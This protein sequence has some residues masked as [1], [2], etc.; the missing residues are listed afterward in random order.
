MNVQNSWQKSPV[1]EIIL[2]IFPSAHLRI[3]LHLKGIVSFI[4]TRCPSKREL[5]EL[6]GH[7]LLI[8]PNLPI[9]D[10]HTDEFRDQEYSMVDYTG[11]I[12]DEKLNG[13]DKASRMIISSIIGRNVIDSASDLR[14]LYN[15]IY[16]LS[17]IIHDM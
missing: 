16:N 11:Q 1:I 17:N 6:E 3:S 5:K 12:K 10:P 15:S 4:P 13:P 9:W 7:Y 8:T 14:Y 2:Y